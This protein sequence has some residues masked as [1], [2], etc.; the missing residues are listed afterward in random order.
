[1]LLSNVN[2][3][4]IQFLIISTSLQLADMYMKYSSSFPRNTYYK[5]DA[6]VID[7]LFFWTRMVINDHRL[8]RELDFLQMRR[9][10]AKVTRWVELE[11]Q[12][13]VNL[14]WDIVLRLLDPD[15]VY[16]SV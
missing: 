10:R 6:C 13:T 14:W 16:H 9:R 7:S 12:D 1:M 11:T 3:N 5:F 2:I 8:V 15:W 4:L